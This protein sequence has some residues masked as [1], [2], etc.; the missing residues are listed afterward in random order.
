ELAQNNDRAWFQPRKRDFERLLREPMEAL[1][2]AL[3]ERF[4]QRAIPLHADPKRSIF[5]IYRD[6]RF[7]KDKSPY[8][9]HLGANF[10]WVHQGSAHDATDDGAHANGGYLHIQPGNDFV[11]GGLWQATKPRLD[12]FR[13]AIVDDPDRVRD[14]LEEPRFAATF[15]SVSTEETLKRVPPGWP[16]EHPMADL[17]RYKD[18]TF[19]R[20]LGDDE[21]RSPDLPDIIAT[22]FEAA[23]P[24]FRFLATLRG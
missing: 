20:R 4:E 23:L 3:A 12:A 7:A 22:D 9:T 11:G 14:A 10:P 6:T 2:A 21:V 17:F 5:R 19:G 13:Q 16:K 24:V 8:K 15:G 18:I 1:V